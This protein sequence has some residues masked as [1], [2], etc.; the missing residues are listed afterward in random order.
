M[1]T[2]RVILQEYVPSRRLDTE[3]NTTELVKAVCLSGLKH[4]VIHGDMH[5]GNIGLVDRGFV[6]YD[7]GAIIYVDPEMIKDLFGGILTKNVNLVTE[8]LLDNQM[9]HV[10][11]EPDGRVQLTRAVRYIVDYIDHVNVQKLLNQVRADP[12]LNTKILHF[13][14]DPDLFLLSRTMSLL[15][16]TCKSVNENFSYND[17]IMD[18]ITDTDVVM[19]YM[20]LSTL[21]QRGFLD[22]QRLQP[23]NDTQN[24]NIDPTPEEN[25]AYMLVILLLF[26]NLIF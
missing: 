17:V 9:V 7:S 4:G 23:I 19:Q 24:E 13:R 16:G 21:L 20:S 26:L 14:I 3:T 11:K 18:M 8:K 15:E 6:L 2:P 10:T 22:I 25:P 5:P 12:L 1:S